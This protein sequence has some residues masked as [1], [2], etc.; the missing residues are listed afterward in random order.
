[1]PFVSN[2][3]HGLSLGGLALVENGTDKTYTDAPSGETYT[4]RVLEPDTQWGNPEPVTTTLLSLMTNGSQVIKL[5]DENREPSI[6]LTIEASGAAGLAAAE[7]ALVAVVGEPAELKWQPP[8]SASVPTVFDVVWSEL[9]H[10]MDSFEER[11]LRRS[12]KIALQALPYARS[13]TQV[14]TPAVATA[15]PTVVDSGAATTNWTIQ[16]PA[17]A[18]LSVVSGAVRSTYSPAT[19]IGSGLYGTSMRRTATFSTATDKYIAVDW[20]SSIPSIFSLFINGSLTALPEARREPGTVAGF[21]RSWFQVSSTVASVTSFEFN[22]IHP[23][24]TGSAT[25]EIDQVQKAATLPASGS[26]RQLT[27]TITPGGS[28][29][30]EGTIKVEHASSGLGQVIVFSHPIQDG[31]SPPLRQWRVA[32]DTP[33]ADPVGSVSGFQNSLVT[34]MSYMIPAASVPTG[35]VQL[36]A[37]LVKATAGSGTIN[38]AAYSAAAAGAYLGD[39]QNFAVT[40]TF[41]NN[42][43]VLVPLAQLTLPTSKIG[44]AGFVQIDLVSTNLNIDEAWLFA[45]DK[46]RLTVLD[47]GTGTPTVGSISNRLRI[48]APSLAEPFGSIMV[49]VASDWSN[50]HT[51]AASTVLCNQTGHRFEPAGSTVFTVTSGP[52]DASVSLEHYPRGHTNVDV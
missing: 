15:A 49:G 3:V 35:D 25:L 33:T 17:G 28:V 4:F 51:P 29:P 34:T 20:K 44:S 37:R 23:A 27:R 22:I 41:P 30:A 6:A 1:M 39:F 14:I 43:W 9:E 45:M 42:Q 13:A 2:S 52:T 5:R 46:G 12:Y 32:G 24:N 19:S 21:T 50:A 48:T 7:K 18:T 36:W 31:Y 11:F 10:Q 40:R 47:C 38:G 8:S 26:A 16:S